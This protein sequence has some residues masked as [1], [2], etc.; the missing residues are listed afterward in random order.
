MRITT[1]SEYS[2]RAAETQMESCKGADYLDAAFIGEVGELCSLYAK[3]VRGDYDITDRVGDI[4]K[5]AGDCCWMATAKTVQAGYD[6]AELIETDDLEKTHRIALSCWSEPFGMEYLLHEI[7]FYAVLMA[8]TRAGGCSECKDEFK[9]HATMFFA[10]MSVFLDHF[11]LTLADAMTAN[12]AKLS[13]RKA[14]GQIMGS[15]DHREDNL[16]DGEE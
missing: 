1:F 11:G 10:A 13:K 8:D 15:G 12:I 9:R 5:E 14:Q 3:G 2:K 7:A 16:P 4:E 6:L